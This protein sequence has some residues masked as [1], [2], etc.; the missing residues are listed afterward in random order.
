[1]SQLLLASLDLAMIVLVNGAILR[2]MRGN[3]FMGF[4]MIGFIPLANV[5]LAIG[6]LACCPLVRKVTSLSASLHVWVS[7]IGCVI[8]TIVD[9]VLIFG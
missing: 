4:V 6:L 2:M 9:Y 5:A 7:I 8:A 1:M 3:L